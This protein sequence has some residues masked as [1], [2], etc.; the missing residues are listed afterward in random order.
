MSGKKSPIFHLMTDMD[1]VWFHIYEYQQSDVLKEWCFKTVNEYDDKGIC[2]FSK[3][4]LDDNLITLRSLIDFVDQY[5]YLSDSHFSLNWFLDT[6]I[7]SRDIDLTYDDKYAGFGD[8]KTLEVGIL[9]AVL[10]GGYVYN[11]EYYPDGKDHRYLI[12]EK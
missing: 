1:T 10:S 12:W 9:K 2:R 4:G 3:Y 6:L 8:V 5:F 7:E 11:I